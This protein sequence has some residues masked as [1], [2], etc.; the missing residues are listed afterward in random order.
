MKPSKQLLF[1]LIV[2]LGSS[3]AVG[4]QECDYSVPATI[5]NLKT[6]MFVS[7]ITPS[8]LAGKMGRS[9]FP[10][11]HVE[12][13]KQF[14]VLFLVDSS[15]SISSDLAYKP[16]YKQKTVQEVRAAVEKEMSSAP[17]GVQLG[18]GIFN[19]KASF[20]GWFTGNPG[21]L[22]Q[23]ISEAT[24]RLKRPGYG[25]TALYDAI[26]Q[27]AD[28]FG[29]VHPGDSIVLLT[30]GGDSESRIKENE[31]AK[32]LSRKGVRVFV[33][34]LTYSPEAASL[35]QPFRFAIGT[36][37]LTAGV[38]PEERDADVMRE[39]A[40]RT[41]G[42]VVVIDASHP[43][44]IRKKQSTERKAA[45]DLF[46]REDVLSAYLL[47]FSVPNITKEDE[48][49]QLTVKPNSLSKDIILSTPSHLTSCSVATASR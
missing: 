22:P 36:S 26:S 14:R 27:A 16:T 11:A 35:K 49:W 8:N 42:G 23:M 21:E 7:G 3:A 32:K 25:E 18:F 43:Q 37:T 12:R 30:D 31:L 9:S 17:E 28:Q 24:A 46:W 45:L 38:S 13:I 10:I 15:G 5:V 29:A 41:G 2:L 4:L 19:E 34:L 20:S 47:H 39:F 1:S 44:W 6:G 33:L 48:G 40:E